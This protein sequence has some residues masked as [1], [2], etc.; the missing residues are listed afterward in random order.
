MA[1]LHG[2]AKAAF[3]A[4]MAAGRRKKKRAKSAHN[5]GSL[6]TVGRA[7]KKGARKVGK[8]AKRGL[9]V[10]RK[11]LGKGGRGALGSGTPVQRVARLEGAVMDL[12]RAQSATVSKVVEHERRLSH[13]ES[14]LSS[15][16]K[17]RR[18]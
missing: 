4:K 5:A 13:V 3:L 7:I 11:K 9:A 14:T 12:A 6:R 1:K 10:V 8:A 16:A 15:W 18:S 2:A 17:G